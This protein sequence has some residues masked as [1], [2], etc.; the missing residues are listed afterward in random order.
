[1]TPPIPKNTYTHHTRAVAGFSKDVGEELKVAAKFLICLE[2][3][4]CVIHFFFDEIHLRENL[5]NLKQVHWYV[6]LI[7]IM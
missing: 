1:M 4:K 2:Q 3:E 5:L 6:N 7:S